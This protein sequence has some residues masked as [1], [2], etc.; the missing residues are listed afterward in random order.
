MKWKKMAIQDMRNVWRYVV[1]QRNR[2]GSKCSQT[3]ETNCM[4]EQFIKLICTS[5]MNND[6]SELALAMYFQPWKAL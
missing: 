5:Q 4:Y 2:L 6:K 1:S 3:I